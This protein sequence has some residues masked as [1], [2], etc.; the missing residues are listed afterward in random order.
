MA[1]TDDGANVNFYATTANVTTATVNPL[2][3][4]NVPTTTNWQKLSFTFEVTVAGTVSLRVERSTENNAYLYVS[5]YQLE[6][7]STATPFTPYAPSNLDL[8]SM[9]PIKLY[10]TGSFTSST[11]TTTTVTVTNANINYNANNPIEVTSDVFGLTVS[12]I[13]VSGS[14]TGA[15]ISITFPKMN[16]AQTVNYRVYIITI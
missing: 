14:G 6:K 3:K 12:N 9:I 2:Y 10:A 15:T 11:S 1:K 13:S 4:L 16:S 5:E 8:M 7:G